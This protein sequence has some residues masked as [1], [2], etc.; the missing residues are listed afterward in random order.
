MVDRGRVTAN[1]AGHEQRIR[2]SKDPGVDVAPLDAPGYTERLPNFARPLVRSPVTG[3]IVQV[4][5]EPWGNITIKDQSGYTFKMLHNIVAAGSLRV[6]QKVIKG[7]PLG[8][9]GSVAPPNSG[10]TGDHVHL[11]VF[12]PNTKRVDPERLWYDSL[13]GSVLFDGD[14]WVGRFLTMPRKPESGSVK[15]GSAGESLMWRALLD[16]LEAMSRYERAN[17]RKTP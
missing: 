12:D 9:L 15:G 16:R 3:E 7:E 13:S 1:Y 4:K 8:F 10:V 14:D 11:S 17:D 6:G 2:Q 5:A